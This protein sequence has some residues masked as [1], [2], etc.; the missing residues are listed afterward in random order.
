ME[1]HEEAF[2]LSARAHGDTGVVVDLLTET[3][4]RHS[5]Y[6]AGGASRRMKPFLQPGA[7][8]IAD[9]RARTSDHLGSARLEPV[10]EGPSVLFD[11]GLALTGLAAAA[12]VAQGAL[13]EREPHPGAFLAFE[14]LMAAFQIP[15]VWPAIFVRFEAGLL[16]DL[17]FGLDL[18]RCA[19]TGTMDDLIWV[20][21][22]TGRAV[23]REAGAPYADKL[24]KLPPFMLGAQ[25]GLDEGDVRS[26]LDLTG[27]FLEQFV[28]HPQNKPIPSARV[29]MIDKLAEQRR[30]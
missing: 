18:S 4:G 21:P 16:E 20:S 2:V 23:S 5:A 26:G 14:A 13:P 10:G 3:H 12:A 1:F 30:L 8:V 7:R 17:G 6:V 11:D 9:Y 24:L 29:W 27:H 15:S 28:F 22:R 25:A 19:V